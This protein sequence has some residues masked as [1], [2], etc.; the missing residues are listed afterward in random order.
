MRRGQD[1]AGLDVRVLVIQ[2]RRLDRAAEELVGMAAE[3]LV[4]RVLARD[5]DGEPLGP[6]AGAPPHLAKARD[7]AGEGHADRGVELADVDAELERVGRD[8]A[9]EVARDEAVLDLAALLRRVARAVRGDPRGE[10]LAPALLQAKAGEALD[11]LDPLARAQEAD[12]PHALGDEVGQE[13]RALRE[14]RAAALRALVDHG[15]VPH[16]DPPARPSARRRSRRR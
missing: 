12:R 15:R 5:V 7:R 3:E 4:E 11:Q 2:D 9:E 14:G 6:P 16:H 10:V 8:H 1:V 13:L